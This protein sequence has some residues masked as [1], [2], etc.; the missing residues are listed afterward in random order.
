[1]TGTPHMTARIR[2]TVI[3]AAFI[4]LLALAPGAEAAV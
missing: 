1:M 3:I 2:A 4:L